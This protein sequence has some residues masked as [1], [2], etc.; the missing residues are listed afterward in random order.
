[1]VDLMH[2]IGIVHFLIVLRDDT[3]F[4]EMGCLGP[5]NCLCEVYAERIE[6]KVFGTTTILP[7]KIGIMKM[8]NWY[9]V[10]RQKYQLG[11]R[12]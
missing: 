11:I 7:L 6:R 5:N 1:M 12:R 10:L 9:L 3:S 4:G 8:G 2:F